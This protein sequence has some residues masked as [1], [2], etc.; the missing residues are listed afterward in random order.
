MVVA[1]IVFGLV[2]AYLAGEWLAY[3]VSLRAAARP[4]PVQPIVLPISET[5]WPRFCIVASC[6]DG[7]SLIPGLVEHLRQQQ[8]P[9]N[10]IAIWILAD[11]CVD[12]SA[13]V[14]RS[15]GVSVYERNDSQRV[16]KG[17]ALNELLSERLRNESFDALVLFD[18]DAH[19]EADFLRR[20]AAHLTRGES[21]LQGATRSKNPADSAFTR[22][23]D[24]I[25]GLIRLHQRGRAALGLAPMMIGSHGI[26]V[27][28]AALEKIGWR[29]NTG[30]TGDDIELG[31]RCHAAGVQVRY[32]EDLEVTN[33]LPTTA[34]AVR[35]QRRRW[36]CSSLR[37]TPF[38]AP[39][40][41]L[42]CLRRID[43]SFDQLFLLLWNPSFSN[44]FISITVFTLLMAALAWH[45]PVW[46]PWAWA[47][48][49]LWLVDVVYFMAA[50]RMMR[51]NLTW[52]D[53]KAIGA[54]V[55]VRAR[56]LIESF[57]QVRSR[58]WW[59]TWHK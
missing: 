9:P 35:R 26:V 3:A 57:W 52:R 58:D 1:W 49:V 16:G 15:L 32:A 50:F 5:A 34:D 48:V 53:W 59:P 38:Y 13:E 22:V 47:A 42:G 7:E 24:I 30:R 18:I 25:Q 27:G 14:A 46:R 6:R 31:L 17:Y 23:G 20:V 21:A 44:L 28:R 41:I 4:I 11:N 19:V 54:Y 10:R 51:L 45:H 33:D 2:F 39:R 29:I 43:G 56:A 36:T 55:I 12:R 37:L 8:Y 40:L